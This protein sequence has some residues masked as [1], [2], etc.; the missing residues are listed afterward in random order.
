MLRKNLSILAAVQ[1]L[2]TL[3]PAA[4]GFALKKMEDKFAIIL[5]KAELELVNSYL[6]FF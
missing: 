1:F 5:A 3:V 4:A 2:T 6:F